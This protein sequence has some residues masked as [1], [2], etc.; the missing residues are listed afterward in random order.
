MKKQKKARKIIS[1]AITVICCF[2]MILFSSNLIATA[3]QSPQEQIKVILDG[4]Q[5]EFDVPPMI[6]N[7]RTMVP[8]RFIFEALG[9]EVEWDG[10]TQTVTAVKEESYW[11]YDEEKDIDVLT[12]YET[13]VKTTIGQK[14]IYVNGVAKEMD[15]APVI[16]NDRTLVPVRFISEALDCI[17][18]WDGTTRIVY[19]YSS[20]ESD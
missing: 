7:D 18:E 11:Q 12:K 3:N 1:F 20:A 13:I 19:V 2:T 15:V 10:K 17:V 6:I 14:K 5:L 4:T 8:M 16:I 9:A